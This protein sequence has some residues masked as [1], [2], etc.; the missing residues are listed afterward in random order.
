MN[1]RL[2]G[3]FETL[4]SLLRR[5]Q[6]F[7]REPRERSK[8]RPAAGPL[9]PAAAFTLLLVLLQCVVEIGSGRHVPTLLAIHRDRGFWG[10]AA[11]LLGMSAI[12]VWRGLPR[13]VRQVSGFV[14]LILV[15][16]EVTRLSVRLELVRACW[17]TLDL[18][19]RLAIATCWVAACCGLIAVPVWLWRRT[20]PSRTPVWVRW[21]FAAT[22]FI[23]MLEAGSRVIDRRP[24]ASPVK[25]P[26]HWSSH[27]QSDGEFRIAAIGGSTMLG[28]PYEPKVDIPTACAAHLQS[29][30]PARKFT[31][32][33]VA[34]GGIN[35]R[36]AIAQLETLP[37]RPDLILLY[38]GHNEVFFDVDNDVIRPGSCVPLIDLCL[39]WS[40]AYRAC[41]RTFVQ[42]YYADQTRFVRKLF[43]S[44]QYSE[45]VTQE[46]LE[47]F[48]RTLVQFA[49][50]CRKKDIRMIWF[51]PAAAEGT[52]EPNRSYTRRDLTADRQEVIRGRLAEARREELAG[53]W[54]A[55]EQIYRSLLDDY[56]DFAE[57]HHRL[58]EALVQ[59]KR[60]AEA[61][62]SFRAAIDCDGH[63]CQASSSYRQCIVD[64]ARQE[65][66]PLIDAEEELST[67]TSSGLLDRTVIHDN[68]HMTL[69]GYLT[70]GRAAAE[71]AVAESLVADQADA[72]PVEQDR[73]DDAAFLAARNFG[74]DDLATAY[75][76]IAF[77]LDHLSEQRYDPSRRNAAAEQYRHWAE[78]LRTG[79]IQPGEQGTESLTQLGPGGRAAVTVGA[80]RN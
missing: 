28:F 31:V 13:G 18:V 62:L 33:N 50:S 6:L 53:R 36:T 4:T 74:V 45:R 69:R 15:L 25:L 77:A 9:R 51:V 41:S 17:L 54:Q 67:V 30:Y 68:V 16:L 19:V 12:L 65:R 52:F 79:A 34:V 42:H 59:Q 11:A 75:D 38:T 73:F 32:E 57:F 63:P 5:F 35:F 7:Q 49:H 39:E 29:R 58:G 22:L 24:L 56:P 43:D 3:P 48:R 21:W 23:T 71:T 14:A 70:L 1:S 8:G 47:R 55:A 61:K 78:G 80:N 10:P 76:R 20:R 2:T 72:M 44:P 66:I 37:T 60:F 27:D 26:E 64:V 46:R 40:I